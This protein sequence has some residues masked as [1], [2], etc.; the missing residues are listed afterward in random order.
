MTTGGFR[1]RLGLGNARLPFR[2]ASR[3]RSEWEIPPRRAPRLGREWLAALA[4]MAISLAAV[5]YLAALAIRLPAFLAQAVPNSDTVSAPLLATALSRPGHGTVFLGNHA[6]YSDLLLSALALH[7]P[8]RAV[9]SQ[10]VTWAVYA[11]GALLLTATLRRLGGW[12]AAAMGAL[13]SLAAAPALLASEASPT[14][15]VTSL[16]NLVLLGWL[17]AYLLEGRRRSRVA[18]VAPALAVGVVTGLDAVSDP[19]LAVVGVLPFLATGLLLGLR[20]RDRSGATLVF[21]TVAAAVGGFASALLTLAVARALSLKVQPNPV[22]LTSLRAALHTL[23]ILGGDTG[24]AL[25]GILSALGS[26]PLSYVET[27]LG[28]L[29]CAAVVATAVHAGRA[30]AGPR[31]QSGRDAPELAHLVFWTL[32]AVTDLTAFLLTSYAV[33]LSALRYLTP[34]LLASAALLPLLGRRRPAGRALLAVG[35]A[36]LACANAWALAA[37]RLPAPVQE[38]P[39]VRALEASGVRNVYADYWEANVTTW[40]T[41]GRLNVRPVTEC[42]SSGTRLCP[43]LLNAATGWFLDPPDPTAVIVDPSRSVP[44][45]P[46]ATYG[47][48][49]RVIRVGVATIY[50]CAYGLR[51]TPS[52]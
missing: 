38:T 13:L 50:V 33:D 9:S 19:L 15:R 35:V 24:I 49:E 51:L 34:L 52:G 21:G 16:A 47:T 31:A 10:A 20:V 39:L 26:G 23:H 28:L 17:A 30:V 46:S 41:G 45:A 18:I 25:G 7:L 8:D 2:R 22:H 12:T 1:H 36:A 27:G 42:G 48:P 14:G 11:A 44:R 6:G 37:T 3:A 5:A 29:V 40:M 43:V 32:V 4:A